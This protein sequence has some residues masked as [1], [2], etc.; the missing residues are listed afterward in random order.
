[1][2]VSHN[3]QQAQRWLDTA[4]EDLQAARLLR[5]NNVHSAACFHYQQAAEKA[6]KAL[7]YSIDAEPWGHSVLRLISEF[8][9]L[10]ALPQADQWLEC[11]SALDLF[12]IPTRYPDSL[13]DLTPGRVYR[14]TD[15]ERAM[16]CAE[17]IVNGCSAML[18]Q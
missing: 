6:A 15:S 1:M 17:E 16:L 12:Y 2:S 7:W 11:A 5:D 14:A 13:P 9:Q 8:P 3:R 10:E 18:T 4:R